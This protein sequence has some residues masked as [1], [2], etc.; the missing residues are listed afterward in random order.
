MRIIAS[1]FRF[2]LILAFFF[3]IGLL[4]VM[5]LGL[6]SQ[7]EWGLYPLLSWFYFIPAIVIFFGLP[8]LL[9]QIADT[10]DKILAEL[11]RRPLHHNPQDPPNQKS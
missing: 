8:A 11:R 7:E 1:C 4:A 10:L 9:F 5:S 3:I 6:S 2:I